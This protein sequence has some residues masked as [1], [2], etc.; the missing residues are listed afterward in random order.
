MTRLFHNLSR[1]CLGLVALGLLGGLPSLAEAAGIGFRN[2]LNIRVIVQGA[3][4]VNNV[5]RR[6]Q[7][8]IIEP[9]KTL[10]DTNLPEGNREVIIYAGQPN[11]ILHRSVVPFHGRDMTLTI[12][13]DRMTGRIRL[14]K[15][16][17]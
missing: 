9:G 15:S 2:D 17:P 7:P 11:R 8:L 6:G 13:M 10:W 5:V 1:A 4:S 12:N 3:S 14:E 16:N